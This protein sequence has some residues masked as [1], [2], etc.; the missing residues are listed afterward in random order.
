[1]RTTAAN[2]LT[3]EVSTFEHVKYKSP[4]GK[5]TVSSFANIIR[6]GT[7]KR[8]IEK[9]RSGDLEIK[10]R[11]P[12]ISPSGVLLHRSLDNH[13]GLVQ[14]D[15]DEVSDPIGLRESLFADE[16]G[17]YLKRVIHSTL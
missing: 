16:H 5:I 17:N 12:A 8:E 13:I 2:Y 10:K 3:S 6:N 15:F 1:M 7:Y 9:L 11:L 4:N 14:L